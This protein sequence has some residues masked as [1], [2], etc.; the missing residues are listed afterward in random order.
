EG[1]GFGGPALQ[2]FR[3]DGSSLSIERSWARNSGVSLWPCLATAC[4]TAASRR[5]SSD[6]EMAREHL[7]SL[8]YSLQSMYLRVEAMVMPPE[9]SVD[10]S[11]YVLAR[12]DRKAHAR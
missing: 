12:K 5:S 10:E 6:P 11:F 9:M 8:G 1:R 4:C 7:F 3:V 2:R